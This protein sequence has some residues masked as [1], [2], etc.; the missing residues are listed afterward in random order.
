MVV[1]DHCSTP[2]Q[3]PGEGVVG[4]VEVG[5][6]TVAVVVNEGGA[7][8]LHALTEGGFRGRI[9]YSRD[10]QCVPALHSPLGVLDGCPEAYHFA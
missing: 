5:V 1:L 9:Y 2:L 4:V 3:D 6:G 8:P 10:V 7:V